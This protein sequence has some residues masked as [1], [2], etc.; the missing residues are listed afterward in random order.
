MIQTGMN[1]GMH[2]MEQSLAT[3]VKNHMLP[4]DVALTFA[5]DPKEMQR[6]LM[7]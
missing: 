1:S 2:T 3:M 4:L 7:M 6:L 5:Y